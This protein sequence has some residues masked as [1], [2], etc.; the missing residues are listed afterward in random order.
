MSDWQ[1]GRVV[2]VHDRAPVRGLITTP[3]TGLLKKGKLSKVV[4]VRQAE[5]GRVTLKLY[6]MLGCDAEKFYEVEGFP[7]KRFCEH[8]VLTD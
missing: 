5:P 2:C 4:N 8:E 6:A 1:P 3:K 7:W